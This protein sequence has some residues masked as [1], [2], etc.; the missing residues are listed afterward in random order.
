MCNTHFMNKETEGEDGPVG[1]S[2]IDVI[3]CGCSL[4]L[5]LVEQLYI[6]RK[7]WEKSEVRFRDTY[8]GQ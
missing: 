4:E 1:L 5:A 7:L 2:R 6:D 3:P 8:I